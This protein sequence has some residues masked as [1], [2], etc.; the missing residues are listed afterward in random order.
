MKIIDWTKMREKKEALRLMLNSRY[1]CYL[2]MSRREW[3]PIDMVDALDLLSFQFKENT[4]VRSFAVERLTKATDHVFTN[5]AITDDLKEIGSYLLQL[6]Q[7]LRYDKVEEGALSD[8]A[9][10]LI[11]RSIINE[12]IGIQ[13]FWNLTVEKRSPLF[14]NILKEFISACNSSSEG[15]KLLGYLKSQEEACFLSVYSEFIVSAK[16]IRAFKS[17]ASGERLIEKTKSRT[18]QKMAEQRRRV[19]LSCIVSGV[20]LK[21]KALNIL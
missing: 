3:A 19:F 16:I 20:T 11:Q 18:I 1:Y 5:K 4:E 12:Q 7:A 9:K 21:C 10:F 2:Q 15:L 8:L 6:V 13:Y 14:K 17:T